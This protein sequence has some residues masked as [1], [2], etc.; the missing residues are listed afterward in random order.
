MPGNSDK[1][2]G[3]FRGTVM[4]NLD[5]MVS[6]R[7]QAMVPDVYGDRPSG[8]ALPCLPLAGRQSGTFVVPAIGSNVWVEFERGDPDF[9]IWVGGFWDASTEPPQGGPR[10]GP[11]GTRIVLQSPMHHSITVSD[12]DDGTGGILLRSADGASLQISRVGI[13]IQNGNGASLQLV[14]PSVD[15]NAGALV[16]T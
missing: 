4:N 16:V 15:I 1:Y 3:K 11:A 12:M 14:G 7:I 6:G 2:F 13:L 10:P 9:P 5:P 8:W